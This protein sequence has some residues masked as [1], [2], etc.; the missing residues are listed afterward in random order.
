MKTEGSQKSSALQPTSAKYPK[1]CPREL[2]KGLFTLVTGEGLLAPVLLCLL[3][4]AQ[5]RQEKAQP[6]KQQ[7]W[8]ETWSWRLCFL[9]CF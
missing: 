6:W 3:I 7:T 4:S 9:L 2:G 5:A 8:W 1:P